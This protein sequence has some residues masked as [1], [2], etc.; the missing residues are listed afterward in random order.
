[1]L[2]PQDLLAAVRLAM[3]SSGGTTYPELAASL[4]MSASEVHAAIK[5]AS[6]CGLVDEATRKA[7][8]SALLEFAVHGLRYV[9]PPSWSGVAR[10]VPTSYAAPPLNGSIAQGDE[11]PPVWP[12]PAGQVR[13]QGLR[14]LYRSVPDAALRDADLYEW[15][16][17]LDAIRAGRA[18]ERQLAVELLRKRLT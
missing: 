8:R 18:R 16:A 3:P 15:L 14:P 5:R 4:C 17:L 6:Q 7:K 13:G 10:G 1:M 12:H 2:K 9:F 11:L